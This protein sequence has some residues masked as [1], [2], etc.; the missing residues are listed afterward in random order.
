MNKDY[1]GRGHEISAFGV[2]RF[3]I[4]FVKT[5]EP[6]GCTEKVQRNRMKLLMYSLTYQL[7]CLINLIFNINMLIHLHCRS[8]ATIQVKKK[9][10][11]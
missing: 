7:I 11:Y 4:L 5:T 10:F 2:L 8:P 1:S 6:Y 3:S 9:L